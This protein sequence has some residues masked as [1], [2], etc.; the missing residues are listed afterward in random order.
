MN[1]NGLKRIG[2]I[3]DTHI[4]E[5][6]PELPREV[7]EVFKGVDM[8]LHA[9]DMHAIRVLDWLEKIAPVLAARGN[10]DGPGFQS[11]DKGSTA[12]D[13]RIKHA[14]VIE[15]D[16]LKIGVV[17]DFPFP[18]E[19]DY[20]SIDAFLDRD[21]GGHVDI[22][23]CG[24]THLAKISEYKGIL[25][26]NPG[27]PTLPNNYSSRLGNVGILEI[28]DGKARAEILQLGEQKGN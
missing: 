13:S 8:I 21:F 20:L 12:Q 4:P 9:G 3:S 10:G 23:V 22:V 17:H 1:K 24:H 14:Q 25:I 19:A 28:E 26:I 16:G 18:E 11:T 15:C 5:S 27:S 6:M 2:L 7:L